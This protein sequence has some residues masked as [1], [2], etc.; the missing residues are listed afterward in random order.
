[1][2]ERL[3]TSSVQSGKA[4]FCA[5]MLNLCKSKSL[6]V[7]ELLKHE[8]NSSLIWYFSLSFVFFIIFY[9]IVKQIHMMCSF[10]LARICFGPKPTSRRTPREG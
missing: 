8:S 2:A 5:V 10:H 7:L 3:E 6:M 1:M 4:H 9:N